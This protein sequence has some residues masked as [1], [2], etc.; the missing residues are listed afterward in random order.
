M[1]FLFIFLFIY[2]F[3]FY[4]FFFFFFFFSDFS[5]N[6]LGEFEVINCFRRSGTVV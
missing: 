1:C 2:F 6:W 4:L 5:E 3:F